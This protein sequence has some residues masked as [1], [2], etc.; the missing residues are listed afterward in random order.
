MKVIPLVVAIALSASAGLCNA[1]PKKPSVSDFFGKWVVTD[2]VGYGDISGGVPEA[3]HVLGLVLTISPKGIDFD[4]DRCTPNGAF[5]VSEIDT[6]AKLK[7]FFNEPLSDT[8]LPARTTMLDSTN[9]TP[10][11]RMDETRILFGWNGVVVRAVQ[12][13]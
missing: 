5:F 9:C 4:K 1:Q 6:A 7:E 8:S 3:K 2:I 13:K 12:N 11:L 10:I